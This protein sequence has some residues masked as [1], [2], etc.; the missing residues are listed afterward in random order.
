RRRK[1]RTSP[2]RPERGM[3]A[4]STGAYEGAATRGGKPAGGRPSNGGRL[5]RKEGERTSS[6]PPVRALQASPPPEAPPGPFGQERRSP[7]PCQAKGTSGAPA[8]ARSGA[9]SSPRARSSP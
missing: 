2:E 8:G 9:A 3:A 7:N 4:R 5:P 6:A 1:G